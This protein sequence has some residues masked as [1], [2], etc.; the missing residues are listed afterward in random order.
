MSESSMKRDGI[1]AT[2]AWDDAVEDLYA[3]WRKDAEAAR[4]VH[5]ALGQRLRVRSTVVGV[6]V[7]IAGLAAAAIALAPIVAADAYSAATRGI[8]PLVMHGIVA[9]LAALAAILT[10]ALAIAKPAV[11][12][13][14][15]RVAALRYRSLDRAMTAMLALA[16][17]ARPS[18]D[19]AL[20]SVRERLTRYERESPGV[21]DRTRTKLEASLEAADAVAA[22]ASRRPVVGDAR[23]TAAT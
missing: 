23:S 20:A 3:S 8:D 22:P 19:E 13:E 9:S 10:T 14:R 2:F 11:R 21:R 5:A 12:A 6:L 17:E 1:V 16:R 18:S 7:V 4:R 15:H